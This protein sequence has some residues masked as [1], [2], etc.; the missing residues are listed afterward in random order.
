MMKPRL[1]AALLMAALVGS[2]AQACPTFAH[3]QGRVQLVSNSMVVNGLPMRVLHFD[4]DQ[5]AGEVLAYYRQ[6]WRGKGPLAA[7]EH[8]LDGWQVISAMRADC[9]YTVQVR[10][11]G[12]GSQALL[13][14]SEM[15]DERAGKVRRWSLPM[16]PSSELLSDIAHDEP[17]KPGQT[18]VVTNGFSPRANADYYAQN[19][20]GQGWTL[21]DEQS[22]QVGGQS[23]VVMRLRKDLALLE[24]VISQKGSGSTV[25]ANWQGRP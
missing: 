11:A 3:P 13:S 17:D 12:L 9:F 4:G 19:L 8:E 6:L 7:M 25:V 21:I 16:P 22:P 10:A 14:V 23:H 15:P 20:A 18:W 24:L 5:T 1:F 2:Q